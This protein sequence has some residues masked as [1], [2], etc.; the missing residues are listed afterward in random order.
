MTVR[1]MQFEQSLGVRSS[2]YFFRKSSYGPPT[3]ESYD[4]DFSTLRHLESIGFEIGYH[5]N[6]YENVRYDLEEV[7]TEIETDLEYWSSNVRL[8]TFVPHGG[9]P[10][11]NREGNSDLGFH[12]SLQ[13]LA[14]VYSGNGVCVDLNW[15]DGHVEFETVKDPREVARAAVNGSQ[16]HFLFHP[17]YYGDD[18]SEMWLDRP[19]SKE[20]WWRRL[21]QLD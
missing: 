15:S 12:E 2:C 10:G 20:R 1:L 5:F 11:P 21:W 8:R 19:I 18:L 14:W 9:R 3:E 4:I 13:H 6:A 7:T 17:Q 16:I